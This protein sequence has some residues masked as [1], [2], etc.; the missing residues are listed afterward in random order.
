MPGM[1]IV[2]SGATGL[3]GRPLVATL[4]NRGDSVTALTRDPEKARVS[5]PS[6]VTCL[7]WSGEDTA[8]KAAVAEADAVVN[9]A[10]E[11][12][13]DKRWTVSQ[14]R[15]IKE[16]R[17]QTTR[18][19]TEVFKSNP[20]RKRT[21][22]NAS[23]IGYYGPRGD[24]VLTEASGQGHDFLAEVVTSWEAEAR[25]AE[26][27][28]AR[29]V[30]VRTGIVLSASGG[31]LPRLALPFKYFAGGIMG[32]ANQWISWI[33]IDDEVGLILLALSDGNLQGPINATA[34]RP[35][36]MDEFSHALGRALHRPVWVPGIRHVIPIA[37]GE[38]AEVALCSQR[39]E[40]DR[41]REH[42]Y[43]FQFPGLAPALQSLLTV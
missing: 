2:V 9:L 31:A 18:A 15:R 28:G 27:W 11:P 33:H 32:P 19:I 36:Q 16:S 1:K 22:L 8:W 38:R 21:H 20:D 3:I 6:A 29:V 13:A 17:V 30:M 12:V 10:G 23:A 25:E 7:P 41:A 5:L 35:V 34:P 14:K 24:E 39:V 37:L 43:T 40:P 26:N 4:I 42:G